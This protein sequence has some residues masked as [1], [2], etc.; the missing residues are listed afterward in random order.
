[1]CCAMQ[2]SGL[3]RQARRARGG[4]PRALDPQK[5]QRSLK[6]AAMLATNCKLQ[7]GDWKLEAEDLTR[8]GAWRIT[9]RVYP[10]PH[11]LV[12]PD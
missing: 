9:L 11:S 4:F 10:M 6:K 12:R 5:D 7:T 8:Q 2:E 3:T 1:M